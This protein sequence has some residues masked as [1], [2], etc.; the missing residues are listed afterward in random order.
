MQQ[1]ENLQTE[2]FKVI[3]TGSPTDNGQ[4]EA[5]DYNRDFISN[6][7]EMISSVSNFFDQWTEH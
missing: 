6:Q 1:T 2:F 3:D 7:M 4:Q 5:I